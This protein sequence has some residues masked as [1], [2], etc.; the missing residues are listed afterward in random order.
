MNR[1]LSALAA[2]HLFLYRPAIY[3]DQT[4]EVTGKLWF[5]KGILPKMALSHARDLL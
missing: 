1:T 4:A 3:N 2:F 5:S